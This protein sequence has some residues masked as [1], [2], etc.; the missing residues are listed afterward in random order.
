MESVIVK[1]VKQRG[2]ILFVIFSTIAILL[3]A[4]LLILARKTQKAGQKLKGYQISA[5]TKLS[6]TEQ[7]TFT[8]LYTSAFDI[9]I[10]HTNNGEEW[11][12]IPTIEASFIAPFVKDAVWESRGRIK[13]ELRTMDKDK[14]HRSV[15]I[16]KTSNPKA[17]GSFLLFLEHFHTLDGAYFY[18]INKE[19]PF[20][21]WYKS[22]AF[23][24]PEKFSE[25]TLIASGWKE[26]IPYSGKDELKKLK[27]VK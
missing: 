5:F 21:I 2:E 24:I 12:D 17:S 6:A 7:G 3:C 13:W 22:G 10:Y 9:D 8:D 4:G 15:Y 11:P 25:G 19:Q 20:T 1:P 18:G 16:G 23:S 27:R 26:A 14:V